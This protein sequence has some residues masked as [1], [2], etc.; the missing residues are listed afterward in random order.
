MNNHRCIIIYKSAL[1]QSDSLLIIREP[2]C[3]SFRRNSP[4]F[5]HSKAGYANGPWFFWSARVYPSS[6]NGAFYLTHV[7]QSQRLS[8]ECIST[9][10]WL[11][12]LYITV[13]EPIHTTYS[14]DLVLNSL[15]IEL[16]TV[17]NVWLSWTENQPLRGFICGKNVF[18][19]HWCVFSRY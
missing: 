2:L 5:P 18:R 15:I 1:S 10:H 11:S 17:R 9:S 12:M 7:E 14:S 16:R 19:N 6:H 13:N 8:P 4:H 3:D